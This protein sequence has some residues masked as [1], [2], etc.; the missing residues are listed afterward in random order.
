VLGI[1]VLT[2]LGKIFPLFCYRQGASWRERLAL[3]I[4]L[5]PRGEVGAGIL[6]LLWAMVSADP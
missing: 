4:G 1:T 3:T 6:T 5:W 2:N